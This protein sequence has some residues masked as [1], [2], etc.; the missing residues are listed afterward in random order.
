M[1]KNGEFSALV[2]CD[3]WIHLAGAP[4]GKI[5][6]RERDERQQARNSGHGDWIMR[7]DAE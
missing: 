2:Q 1:L 6:R 7:A 5:A 3:E 4:R